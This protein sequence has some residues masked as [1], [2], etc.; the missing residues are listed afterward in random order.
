MYARQKERNV[1]EEE[2]DD[3]E[4]SEKT[5]VVVVDE[6]TSSKLPRT[7][8]H[9]DEQTNQALIWTAEEYRIVRQKHRIV[10]SL[11]GSLPG[12]RQQDATR[13]LPVLL[14]KEETYVLERN[15][16]AKVRKRRSGG[17]SVLEEEEEEEMVEIDAKEKKR[18]QAKLRARKASKKSQWGGAAKKKQ[19]TAAVKKKKEEDDNEGEEK[20][21][22][23]DKIVDWEHVLGKTSSVVLPLTSEMDA[24]LDE[25]AVEEEEE[26]DAFHERVWRKMSKIDRYKCAVFKD[27]HEKGFTMTSAA[28]FGGDYLAYPGDPMLFHAYF[29]VRVLETGEKMTPLSCSSVT[30]M[31]HAARKNVVFAFCGE[32]GDEGGGSDDSVLRIRYFTCVPDIE[33]SSNR[34][35]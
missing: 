7:T 30:R 18:E 19:K 13:G 29:T 21:I 10:G 31:A 24:R 23:S 22:K 3:D 1:E 28:K 17:F 20:T 14:S 4:K 9:L 11:L 32:G 2:E 8:V 16:W 33:L 15:G 5:V 12:Y 35:F 26:E 25:P 6:I 34:G 27:L